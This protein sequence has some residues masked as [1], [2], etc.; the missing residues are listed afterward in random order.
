MKIAFIALTGMALLGQTS[1]DLG[2]TDT[3]I[4]PGLPY[5]VH[6]PARP[7]P[8]VVAPAAQP[9]GAPS[10]AIVLFDGASLAQW[11]A[12]RLNLVNPVSTQQPAGWKVE[13]G[14]FE[15]VPRSG[16]IATKEK[17]GDVQLHIEWA[18]PTEVRGTSQNRGNSGIFL[19]GRY[20]VQVLDSYQNPTYADG[21]A[22]AI[23]GQWPPLVN[24]ARKPGEWQSFDIVFE[25]PRFDGGKPVTPAYLT[26]FLNGVLLHNRKEVAGPT[27]H[28]AL[29]KYAPQPAED[30][31]MLQD[32]GTPVR[33]RNIWVRRV[34][35]YDQPEK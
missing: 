10:D 31:L 9:G 12:A 32:H 13:N 33:Y 15:V 17:F 18:A 28:R 6:D 16:D 27:V 22:G 24:P 23:Y 35:G 2:Y 5:H 14:Y 1:G 7:H 34:R 11:T 3:P 19:Q 8:K 30:S 20:E 26:V 29:A 4:L 25:A 21:Q